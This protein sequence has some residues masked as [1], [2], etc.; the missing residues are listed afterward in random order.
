MGTYLILTTNWVE[1]I[2]ILIGFS[3]DLTKRIEFISK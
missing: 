2:T 3:G 1:K